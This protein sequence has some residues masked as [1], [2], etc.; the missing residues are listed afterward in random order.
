MTLWS[1]NKGQFI[2]FWILFSVTHAIPSPV[3]HCFWN[4]NPGRS[5][6]DMLAAQRKRMQRNTETYVAALGPGQGQAVSGQGHDHVAL[7][8]GPVH[9]HLV[10]GIIQADLRDKINTEVRAMVLA[11]CRSETTMTLKSEAL[12]GGPIPP[13]THRFHQS[14]L[15][16]ETP[17]LCSSKYNRTAKGLGLSFICETH[18]VPLILP[19][20]V[21]HTLQ[22][23]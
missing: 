15:P 11:S 23:Q 3:T 12:G 10:V 17:V 14:H 20:P 9:H 16:P 6:R 18:L 22:Q 5:Q 1:T 8:S 19:P 7:L 2:I 13:T 4:E 21:R